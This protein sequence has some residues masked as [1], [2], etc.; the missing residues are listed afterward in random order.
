[1]KKWSKDSTLLL[2]ILNVYL[3]RYQH[4]DAAKETTRKPYQEPEQ[5]GNVLQFPQY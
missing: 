2:Q 1:M 5:H 4:K 3:A